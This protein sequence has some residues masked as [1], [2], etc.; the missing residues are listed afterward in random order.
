MFCGPWLGAY[1]RL[2]GPAPLAPRSFFSVPFENLYK[3]FF[4]KG[5]E[6]V[7]L[8]HGSGRFAFCKEGKRRTEAGRL[9]HC[10][11]A[12]SAIVWSARGLPSQKPRASTVK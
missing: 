5:R 4:A 12:E 1:T 9:T 11:Q 3:H 6:F 2:D 10:L 7:V 8:W